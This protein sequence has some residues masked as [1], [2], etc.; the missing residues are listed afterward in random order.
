MAYKTM[1]FSRSSGRYN[2]DLTINSM[3]MVNKVV[4]VVYV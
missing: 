3:L 2:A 1:T 4:G